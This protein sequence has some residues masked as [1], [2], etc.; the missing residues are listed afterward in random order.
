MVALTRSMSAD[1]N[2]VSRSSDDGEGLSNGTTTAK[3]HAPGKGNM[4]ERTPNNRNAMV[5]GQG[6]IRHTHLELIWDH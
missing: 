2:A 6:H 5:E 1:T 3:D 4:T